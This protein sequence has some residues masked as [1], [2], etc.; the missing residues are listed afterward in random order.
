MD[1]EQLD[2]FLVVAPG[3][4]HFLGEEARTH[5]FKVTSVEAAGVHLSGPWS[6][7][8]RANLVLRGASRVLVRV[9]SF[10]AM[11][12]AQLDKRT[13]KLPW[14]DWLPGDTLCRVEATCRKSRIYHHRAAAQRV[15][16]AM[17]DAGLRIGPKAEIVVRLRIDDD[18]ATF[19]LDSS[20][21]LL[22]RRGFKPE[23]N[24]A[25]L[26]ETLASLFLRAAGFDGTASVY[27]PMCGSGTFVLEAADWACEQ[28]AGRARRFA[29]E[30][31]ASFD[32][33]AWAD[34]R[35]DAEVAGPVRFFGS[36][37]D[38]GAVRMATANATSAGLEAVTAFHRAAIADATPP[39]ETP[40]LVITNPPYGGR[41]GKSGALHGLYGAFGAVMKER[42]SGWR[43][44]LVTSEAGLTKSTG[45]PWQPPGPIVDH[46]G[47]KVRLWQVQL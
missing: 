31:F 25:P 14:L 1:T 23:V 18:L 42:F 45:L 4:A 21:A 34:L 26:R 10:R 32:R 47:R 9:A 36:D 20:G 15:E 37:R 7:V 11:H 6:E 24:K 46:G 30:Q 39:T 33:A 40:G 29:F 43:V 3:L 19:S 12:L 28:Q 41:I 44:A 35:I 38:D 17:A 8:W 22:H 13:R 16:R 5:G 27:D 2:I